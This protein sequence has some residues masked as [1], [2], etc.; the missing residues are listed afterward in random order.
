SLWVWVLLVLSASLLFSQV[1]STAPA[2]RVDE[3]KI[4]LLTGQTSRLELP[5]FSAA[6]RPLKAHLQV[7]LLQENGKILGSKDMDITVVPG[8]HAVAVPWPIGTNSDSI[9]VVY[10]WRLHYAITPSAQ[11]DFPQQ[12]GI[13]QLSQIIPDLPRI[14]VATLSHVLRGTSFPVRVRVDDIRTGRALSGVWVEAECDLDHERQKQ[15]PPVQHAKTDAHGDAVVIFKVPS[16]LEKDPHI[17]ITRQ[18]GAWLASKSVELDLLNRAD[19]TVSTDKPIYQPGQV[20]HM[21]A[22]IFGPGSHAL[23]NAAVKFVV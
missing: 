18:R 1:S 8:T 23:A 19:V 13:V 3:Q 2:L 16:D 11:S 15:H 22:L 6:H 12:E 5:V 17:Y 10:W 7:E 21:R 4:Q 20:L 14:Q 9:S